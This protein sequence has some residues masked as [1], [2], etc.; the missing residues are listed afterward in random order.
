L[1]TRDILSTSLKRYV[2][3][4]VAGVALIL[5]ILVILPG[6]AEAQQAEQ[7]NPVEEN[8]AP[9]AS[10]QPAP[11]PS[12]PSSSTRWVVDP[13][14]SLW[15]ISQ[16]HI[17]PGATP[18]QIAYE[19][20]RIFELNRDRIGDN[21]NLI[22]PGQEFLLPPVVVE[23]AAS[24][25]LGTSGSA[26]LVEP[27]VTTTPG[28]VMSEEPVTIEEPVVPR[29]YGGIGDPQFER[30]DEPDTP[31]AASADEG[32]EE[33]PT[34]S[35]TEISDPFGLISDP[36]GLSAPLIK[37]YNE[38]KGSRQLLGLAIIALTLLIASL[39]ALR[40]PM[41]RSVGNPYTTWRVPGGY[42]GYHEGHTP[43]PADAVEGLEGP[44]PTRTEDAGPP[45]A[46]APAA[47]QPTDDDA[48][49]TA[50]SRGKGRLRRSPPIPPSSRRRPPR[51]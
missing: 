6:K 17:G 16:E 4:V 8:G 33:T 20:E 26:A 38:Y 50:A 32:N 11:E 23:P 39:L 47:R 24:E 22:F 18:Q 5:A 25:E 45:P 40:M 9:A 36:F 31:A 49:L 29:T 19:V 35:A 48:S 34:T 15:S 13:G 21:P 1:S 51:I 2:G 3:I 43:A 42:G 37:F 46:S 10:P 7:N 44:S 30:V 28:P 41:K 12:T 27:A 14:E